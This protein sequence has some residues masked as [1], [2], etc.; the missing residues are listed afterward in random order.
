[1]PA[2]NPDQLAYARTLLELAR[3]D[4][5]AFRILAADP[6]LADGVV[7]LHA[8]QAIEKAIKAVMVGSGLRLERR[9]DLDYLVGILDDNHV[10][11]PEELRELSWLTPWAMDLRYDLASHDLDRETSLSLAVRAVQWAAGEVDALS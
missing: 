5:A 6:D 8:Q 10:A 3:N 2:P 1:M 4:L 9:H 11:V 7:G